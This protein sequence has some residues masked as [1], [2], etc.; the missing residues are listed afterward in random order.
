MCISY[1]YIYIYM[2]ICKI[3][4][5]KILTIKTYP[6]LILKVNTLKNYSVQKIYPR[7]IVLLLNF[8]FHWHY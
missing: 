2:Y 5:K 6:N 7:K 3:T 8:C 1:L 4:T